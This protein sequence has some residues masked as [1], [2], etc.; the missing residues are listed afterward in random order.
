L[1]QLSDASGQL[2]LTEVATGSFKKTELKS[3]DVF[4]VDIGTEAFIWVGKGASK[5][6]ESFGPTIRYNVV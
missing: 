4:I 3:D 2:K 1:H 5:K 6:R